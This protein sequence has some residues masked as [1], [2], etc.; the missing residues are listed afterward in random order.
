[1]PATNLCLGVFWW[2]GQSPSSQLQHGDIYYEVTQRTL[3]QIKG[4]KPKYSR[5]PGDWNWELESS[6]EPGFLFIEAAGLSARSLSLSL[7]V[8]LSLSFSLDLCLCASLC[9]LYFPHSS[10]SLIRV[11]MNLPFYHWQ[12]PCVILFRLKRRVYNSYTSSFQTRPHRSCIHTKS[13]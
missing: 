3:T 12:L 13:M 4:Q 8:S 6:Q 10:D 7:S 11:K 5:T 2:V 1:M 9:D